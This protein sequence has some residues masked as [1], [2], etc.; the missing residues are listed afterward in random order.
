MDLGSCARTHSVKVKNEYAQLLAKAEAEND[1]KTVGELNR[2]RL[3]YENIVR[4]LFFSSSYLV[5]PFAKG[6]STDG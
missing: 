3:E 2:L 4:R 6:V 5:A 1:T